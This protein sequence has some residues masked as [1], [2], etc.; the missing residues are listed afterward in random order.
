MGTL[1]KPFDHPIMAQIAIC[2]TGIGLTTMVM[3]L[4]HG[5]LP[6]GNSL[7]WSQNPLTNV[8]SALAASLMFSQICTFP[9]L[10][11]LEVLLFKSLTLSKSKDVIMSLP[12][13]INALMVSVLLLIAGPVLHLELVSHNSTDSSYYLTVYIHRTVLGMAIALC[14]IPS[15]L[16]GFLI[17]LVRPR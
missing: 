2:S 6:W 15:S 14:S 3:I 16:A 4:C 11:S 10:Y 12:P 13:L 17:A 5:R 8:S 9:L 7:N 1:K